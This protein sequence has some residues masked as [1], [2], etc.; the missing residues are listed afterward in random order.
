[1]QSPPRRCI[2]LTSDMEIGH[3]IAVSLDNQPLA[4]SGRILLQ[5]MS[6]E[7]ATGFRTEPATAT[8]KRITDIG[9]DPWQVKELTGTVRFNRPMKITA[10]DFNG[11]PTGPV[12]ATTELRLQ[13]KTVYYL[14]SQ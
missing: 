13:P 14:I 5:I 2:T 12:V 11:Y 8:I 9:R 7:K 6:E 3:I 1:M 4:T 10:L